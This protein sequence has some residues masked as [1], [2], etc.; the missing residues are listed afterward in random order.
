MKLER[1]ADLVFF[2]LTEGN[3]EAI[4]SLQC[5]ITYIGSFIHVA[6]CTNLLAVMNG[7]PFVQKGQRLDIL[8]MCMAV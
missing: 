5:K 3:L 1:I 4:V 8:F 2:S 6:K 7:R